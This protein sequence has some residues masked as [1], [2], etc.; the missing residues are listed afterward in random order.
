LPVRKQFAPDTTM[1]LKSLSIPKRKNN[2]KKCLV[3][4]PIIFLLLLFIRY[5]IL[6]CNAST[7]DPIAAAPFFDSKLS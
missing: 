5:G 1:W 7:H 3:L 2:N 6:E 4:N